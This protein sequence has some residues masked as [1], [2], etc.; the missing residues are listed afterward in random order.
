MSNAQRASK[1]LR[2][3]WIFFGLAVAWAAIAVV[4]LA[5]YHVAEPAGVLSITTNGHTYFGHP[6]ALSM[7]ESD[8]ISFFTIVITLGAGLVVGGVDLAVRTVRKSGRMGVAS[9]VAG[10][11]LILVSVLGLLF[12]LLGIGVVGVLLIFS[13]HSGRVRL[14]EVS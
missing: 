11:V 12:G 2:G 8:P 7:Y 3:A 13:G 1:G 10:S 4:A 14:R 6:P 9:V 5:S